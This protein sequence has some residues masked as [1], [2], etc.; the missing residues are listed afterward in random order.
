[1]GGVSK[2]PLNY[3]HTAKGFKLGAYGQL[4]ASHATRLLPTLGHSQAATLLDFVPRMPGPLRFAMR[5]DTLSAPLALVAFSLLSIGSAAPAFADRVLTDDGRIIKPLKARETPS[6]YILEFENGTIELKGK[7]GIASVEIEGDMSDYV[8]KNDDERK[9]LDDGYIRY[10]GKW[11]TKPAYSSLLK[12]E[13]KKSKKRTEEL[14][15]HADFSNPWVKETSH[16]LVRTNNSPELLNY[17]CDLLEAYYK[18]MNKRIGIKP[19]PTYRKIKMTVNIYSSRDEFYTWAKDTNYPGISRGVAGFFTPGDNSLNFFHN[20][21]EP[22]NSNWIALHECTHLLTYLIDQQ[23]QS[24]I[25]VNEGIA[26]YLGSSDI[27]IGKKGKITIKPGKLQSD[28]VLTVQQAI[29]DE[30]DIKLE[31]LFLI[32]KKDFQSFQYAHAWSFVYFLN[33][34]KKGK[35]SKGFNKFFKDLYTLKGVDFDAVL[36]AGKTG[37]GKKVSPA[38]IRKLLLSKIGEKDAAKLETQ[39]KTFIAGIPIEAPAAR[40][41]RGMSSV[42]KGDF[43]AALGDLDYA[44]EAGLEDPQAFFARGRAKLFSGEPE[45]AI[46]DLEQ[47]VDMDPLNASF[48]F[49]LSQAMLAGPP[50]IVG[51]EGK[52]DGAREQAGLALELNPENPRYQKWFEEFQ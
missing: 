4:E 25:W 28:R 24:Q 22:A 18:L 32:E 29:K 8:P 23:Y 52:M 7:D 13:F 35:Y 33:N 11:M 17:Y 30:T 40:L 6:G 51:G 12:K 38:N 14:A 21:D 39:W 49:F 37:T 5:F 48:R 9:K 31:D 42:M 27:T 44:I 45:A 16:F 19:T 2:E 3:D 41:K 43:E 26:D 36:G 15:L 47:A 34:Y 1:M 20:Y 10:R 46:K 50:S